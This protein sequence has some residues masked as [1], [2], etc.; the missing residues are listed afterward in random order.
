MIKELFQPARVGFRL[1]A[2]WLF[3]VFVCMLTSRDEFAFLTFV[4]FMNPIV[5]WGAFAAAALGF[6]LLAAR[7]PKSAT[8]SR[9]LTACVFGVM[10]LAVFRVRDPYFALGVLLTLAIFGYYIFEKLKPETIRLSGMGVKAILLAAALIYFIYVGGL[11][12]MRYLNHQAPA[13]DFGIFTQ[14]F[15]SMKET[16]LPNTT[17]ERDMFL[18]HF[19]VHI[20]PI[21]YLLLPFYALFPS[22]VT[23]QLA[24]AAV[25][26][27]GI[28]PLYLL[29]RHYG[30]S[31]KITA[32]VGVAYCMFPALM[33]GCF[34]DIHENMF[35][36]PLLLWLFYFYE[37]KRFAGVYIFAVLTLMVKEDAMIYVASFALFILLSR[38]EWK[39]GSI[40]LGMALAYFICAVALLNTFGR[41]AMTGRFENYM[42]D[43]RL[44]LIGVI[45]T[46]LKNPA[47][48]LYEIFNSEKLLFLLIMLA[49]LGFLPFFN[50]K[51][52]R[53]ILLLP[54]LVISL[55]SD[56]PY[57]H[58]IRF[59][60]V[61]GVIAF[62]FYLTVMNLAAIAPRTRR[63]L[64]CF[65][66]A[67][68][69]L[70]SVSQMSTY[71]N[72]LETYITHREE[73]LAINDLLDTVPRDASVEASSC[74]VPYLSQRKEIYRMKSHNKAEYVVIDLRPAHLDKDT[75]TYLQEFLEDGYVI[76]TEE[77]NLLMILRQPDEGAL[78][79]TKIQ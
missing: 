66:A 44:G 24:Q 9:A 67:G 35:L 38:R 20:S 22:P 53:L 54:V 64:A 30:L 56:Y 55:M 50:K 41:G 60:Y 32:A 70:M 57:Q 46:I 63:R 12:T 36:T 45:L 43:Q 33:G 10:F 58:S 2:S 71:L 7:F 37:K 48:L 18:S 29:C 27:S 73:N 31:N 3:A 19:A 59:Q 79:R 52:S 61:F 72:I 26:V 78:C 8:D 28:F 21:Y 23:L 68:C 6:T 47:Y 25:V 4:K 76:I 62:I 5:F 40:L 51:P 15:Y 1:G 75:A 42:T 14:M 39:H 77:E 69:V 49:P 34:Y 16:L 17:V 65:A 13:F 74:F 11:T